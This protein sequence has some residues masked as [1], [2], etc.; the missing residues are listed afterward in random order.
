MSKPKIRFPQYADEWR[1]ASLSSIATEIN[2]KAPIGSIAPVMMITAANGFIEQSQRYST[3]N[4]GSSLVNYTLLRKGELAYNHGYSSLRHYGSCFDLKEDEAR[5]PFVY[6]AFKVNVG[7]PEFWGHYLNC[8]IFDKQLRTM[9]ASTARMDGLLNISFGTYTSLNIRIPTED[10]QNKIAEYFNK[11]NILIEDA[12]LQIE[13]LK[14]LKI[15]HLNR[16][17]PIGGGKTPPM[18]IEGYTEEWKVKE[19]G[20]IATKVTEKNTLNSVAE[21]FTNSAVYGIIS[22]RDFFDHDIAKKENTGNYFIVSDNDFVYNPRISVTAPVGPINRNRT[23]RKGVMSPLYTVFRTHDINPIFLEHY[24]KSNA[25]HKYMRYNGNSGARHDRFS[26]NNDV[27]FKMPIPV[28]SPEEQQQ[29][30]DYFENIDK[31]IKFHEEELERLK[32]LKESCLQE[33]FV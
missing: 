17:F 10:E 33:M 12:Q 4:T 13:R 31:L 27:F 23:G 2:R 8:G 15:C 29:I 3:D 5:I 1:P 19:L 11:Y 28:P 24:F 26:I 6:H 25:W 7:N 32:S 16:L 21:V 14:S 30:A 18:R 20:E 22:Q 9:V